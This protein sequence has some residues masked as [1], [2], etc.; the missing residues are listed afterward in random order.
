[1]VTENKFNSVLPGILK[2]TSSWFT[3]A[4]ELMECGFLHNIGV[5]D[6]YRKLS[7][8][9]RLLELFVEE[10][11]KRNGVAVYLNVVTYNKTAIK[12][13]DS[14]KWHFYG[15]EKNY[16]RI[17]GKS[18]DSRI[19]YYIIDMSKC[20]EIKVCNNEFEEVNS[21]KE[22]GCLSSIMGLFGF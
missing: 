11:K 5:I 13:Y 2:S 4:N 3:I 16:Y 20:K 18:F 6:E 8:G 7:I 22:K 21:K 9:T 15:I 17:N 10:V 14:N 1:M 19:Y 12:F